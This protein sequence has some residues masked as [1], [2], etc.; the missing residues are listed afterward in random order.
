MNS[1]MPC[2]IKAWSLLYDT[3]NAT[4]ER[5]RWTE[6][7]QGQSDD[8]IVVRYHFKLD[9]FD[10]MTIVESTSISKRNQHVVGT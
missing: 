5:L 9:P 4:T 8:M 3:N 1:D 7:S 6:R 10:L 2:P